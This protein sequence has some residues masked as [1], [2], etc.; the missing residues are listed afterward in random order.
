ML[1]WLVT[2]IQELTCLVL[3]LRTRQTQFPPTMHLQ[4]DEFQISKCSQG[5]D[6]P[7]ENKL[8]AG[9]ECHKQICPRLQVVSH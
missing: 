2:G 6:A 3:D 1:W 9:P 5:S 8:H 7:G 4:H